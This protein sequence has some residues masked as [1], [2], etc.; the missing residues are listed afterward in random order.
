MTYVITQ[1]CIGEVYAACQQ[2]CPAD[3]M[4]TV[5]Q[6]LTPVDIGAVTAWLVAQPVP[7]DAR[8]AAAQSLKLPLECGGLTKK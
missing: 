2:V 3:C 8:P 5:A 4:H 7:A 6:R 1:K